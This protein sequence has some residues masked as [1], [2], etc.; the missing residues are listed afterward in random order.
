MAISPHMQKAKDRARKEQVRVALRE[1]ERNKTHQQIAET[2][3]VSRQRV[4]Q[5]LAAAKEKQA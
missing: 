2:L 5:I 4:G 1:L 3:G